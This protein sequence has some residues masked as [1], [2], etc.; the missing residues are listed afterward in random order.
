MP[1][2]S[3]RSYIVFGGLVIVVTIGVTA[4]IVALK[5]KKRDLQK[6]QQYA[7]VKNGNHN[8]VENSDTN[9]NAN[10]NSGEELR[11]LTA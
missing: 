3:Y 4:A 6:K 7:A 11:A 2:E 5:K 10:G 1:E 9:Y 8:G